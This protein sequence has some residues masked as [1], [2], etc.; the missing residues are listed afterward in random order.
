MIKLGVNVDHIATIRQARRTFEPDPVAAALL[1][2][3]GGADVIT[4]HLREDRRHI[5]GRDVRLLKEVVFTKLNLEMSVAPDIVDSAIEIKPDQ[6][7]LV[8]EKRLEIT[9]EGGLDVVSQKKVI[10]DVIKRLTEA[11]I[12][13]SLFIDPEENQISVSK[14]TGA[15]F[16]ELHTGNY[17]LAKDDVK[18]GEFVEKLRAGLTAAQKSGLRVNAGHGLTYHNV[19]LI[20]ESLDV[21]EL[22]IGHSI[23]SRAVFV[24]IEKAVSEMKELIVRHSLQKQ[25][26]S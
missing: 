26:R 14:D 13:V 25:P 16:I 20:V 24:G 10:T 5:Q 1:A 2:T 8:P 18:R 12:C 15:Q 9:T 19:G 4:V 7:T 11:G 22:H 17:A 23:V 21:E 6:V 3:F